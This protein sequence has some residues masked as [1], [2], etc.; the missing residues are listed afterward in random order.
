MVT[1]AGLRACV[2][3][4][5]S[6]RSYGPPQVFPHSC[7][8]P[9]GLRFRPADAGQTPT[10]G[11]SSDGPYHCY[12]EVPSFF[13]RSFLN[14]LQPS[15]DFF[16]FNDIVCYLILFFS[17][18]KIFCNLLKTFFSFNDIVCYLILLSKMPF[19]FPLIF[20]FFLSLKFC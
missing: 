7:R 6:C 15:P 17:Y 19:F 14:I 8:P 5:K 18:F 12:D 13:S 10:G 16:S 2:S 1:S 20:H 9:E 3:P 11:H 4:Y